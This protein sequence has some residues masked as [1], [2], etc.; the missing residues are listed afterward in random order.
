MCGCVGFVSLNGWG[1]W[2]AEAAI[3][4]M[5]NAILHRGPDSGDFWLDPDNGVAL[6]H[7]R[8]AI[9]DLS[10]SGR[11]PMASSSGRYVIVFNGEIYNHLNVRASIAESV[12]SPHEWKGHSDTE[13]LLA[14]IE[15]FGVKPALQRCIGM[16]AFALWD[17]KLRTLTLAR[18][19]LGEKPL[20]YGWNKDTLFFSSELKGIK[21]NP[22]FNAEID[23]DALALYFRHG[24]IPAPYSI[25]RNIRKLPASNMLTL[26][27]GE[28]LEAAQSRKPE[29]YWCLSTAAREPLH[30]FSNATQA[31]DELES[32]LF[33]AVGQQMVADVPLGAFLSGG[34]DSSTVVALMQAQSSSS[35]RTFSIGFREPEFNEADYAKSVA[36]HLKTEH[37]ELYLSAD[38]ALSLVPK[39]GVIWDEPFADSSQLPT[40]LLTQMARQHVTVA[41]SGDGG[42][43]LFYGYGRYQFA[44]SAWEKLS[45]LPVFARKALI[46]TVQ[47]I[48]VQGTDA[49]YRLLKPLGRGR[50]DIDMFGDKL[51]KL[52]DIFQADSPRDLY[53]N[54]ISLNHAPD[55]LV[56]SSS[57][58]PTA[59]TRASDDNGFAAWMMET[60]LGAYLPDDIL[61]KVDRASMAVSLE[62]RVPF[63]D[64]RVVEFALRTPIDL[65]FKNGTGKWLLRQVLYRHVPKALIERPKQGFAIPIATWLRG[66]LRP[67]AE[68]L[69]SFDRLQAGGYLNPQ[70]VR[71]LWDEHLSGHRNWQH[72]LWS[73]LMFQEWLACSE[74]SWSE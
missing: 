1:D 62:T 25:Y 66:P 58:N 18:D 48:P 68:E 45:K 4:K 26:P 57:E 53:L 61:V 14:A 71:S 37:T 51:R 42:D 29:N 13:T 33:S 10:P 65:K 73:I 12:G 47:H 69:L 35:V 50:I 36:D 72:Q 22:R 55:R 67:W 32:L 8:L 43:E 19:R 40:L 46:S 54:L 16:F 52:A 27:V 64:H 44:Q 21:S 23:R 2:N 74:G 49:V 24:Y 7:R 9:L 6:G 59:Y 56:I 3:T 38:D 11:Q 70:V 20:Y 5:M 28:G 17:R 41:L 60:D 15:V 39:L 34:V 30:R 31:V 63:L